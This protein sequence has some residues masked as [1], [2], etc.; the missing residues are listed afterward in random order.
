MARTVAELM[1]LT[2]A[3]LLEEA[4]SLNITG[5]SGMNKTSLA[6]AIVAAETAES[7]DEDDP[8]LDARLERRVN[9]ILED[10][11]IAFRA[12][13]KKATVDESDEVL[14]KLVEDRLTDEERGRVMWGGSSAKHI[15]G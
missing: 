5:A 13:A 6:E 1:E 14:Q 10:I 2:K 9:E 7:A 8:D 3:A 4:Q 11:R 12:G 15:I